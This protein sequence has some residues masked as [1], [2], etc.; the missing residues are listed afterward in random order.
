MT[1]RIRR[2]KALTTATLSFSDIWS[3]HTSQT[4]RRH[5]KPSMS[6]LKASMVAQLRN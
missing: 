6:R 3:P 5:I 2:R 4:D 1:I